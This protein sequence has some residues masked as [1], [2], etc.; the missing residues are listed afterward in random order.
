[1]RER[2]KRDQLVPSVGVLMQHMKNR[3][4][5]FESVSNFYAITNESLSRTRSN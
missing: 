5:S 4:L 3:V 1:M 2:K